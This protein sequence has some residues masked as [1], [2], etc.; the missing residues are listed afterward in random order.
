MSEGDKIVETFLWNYRCHITRLTYYI[1]HEE[2]PC[3][4]E[5]TCWSVEFHFQFWLV[6]HTIT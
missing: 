2:F 5:I 6:K 1:L 4:K 3:R